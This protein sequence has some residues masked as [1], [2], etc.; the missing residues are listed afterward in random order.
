MA[1]RTSLEKELDKGSCR[2][3]PAFLRKPK[4]TC[5]FSRGWGGGGGGGVPDLMSPGL[6]SPM[7][8]T[9]QMRNLVDSYRYFKGNL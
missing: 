7:K 5:D 9:L 3:V 2:F 1:V 8:S 4:A 6:D